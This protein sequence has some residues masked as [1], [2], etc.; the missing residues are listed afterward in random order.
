M[1]IYWFT[2]Q[3]SHGKT[4]LAQLLKI[5][6]IS[7]GK[8]VFH[9]D[10]DDLRS[11]TANVNYT[12][13]GRRDNVNSAQKIAH[14]LHNLGNDVVVSLVSPFRDQREE[15]KTLLKSDIIELYVYTED[16]RERDDYK[17]L[18][19][20]KPI[21]NFIPVDTTDILPKQSLEKILQLISKSI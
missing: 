12:M 8:T 21:E 14:Y 7:K 18:N 19:Y 15:F 4:T 2:G 16:K 3:P 17:Y 13:L 1:A 9:I 10:G 11:L 20:E 6:L 5:E